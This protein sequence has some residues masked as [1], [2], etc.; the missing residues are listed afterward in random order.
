M[1]RSQSSCCTPRKSSSNN[2]RGEMD[3]LFNAFFGS[4]SP[5]K[6]ITSTPPINVAETETAFEIT[7]ELPGLSADD[8]EVELKEGVL[9]ISGERKELE[10]TDDKKYHRVEQKYGPFSR[11]V[12][13]GLPVNEEGVE[14]VYENGILTV[15][16]PKAEEI[17]PHKI[18]VKTV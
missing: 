16:V 4:E 8:V 9:T 10:K 1:V 11:S 5:L 17:K 2:L 13:L 7:A 6:F 15:L 3:Q 18:K 14:A 12:Q